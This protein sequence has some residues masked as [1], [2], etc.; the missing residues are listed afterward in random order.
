MALT[1]LSCRDLKRHGVEGGVVAGC[2]AAHHRSDVFAQSSHIA[3]L[4]TLL[5]RCVT[6][7]NGVTSVRHSASFQLADALSAFCE[8]RS[9][10]SDFAV[11]CAPGWMLP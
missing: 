4:P 2:V 7:A 10:H 1:C 8:M 11:D 5:V 3:S 9:K 6:D